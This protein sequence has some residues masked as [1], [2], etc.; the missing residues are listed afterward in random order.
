M[1]AMPDGP[2]IEDKIVGANLRRIR[3]QAGE[4][5]TELGNALGITFQ[6]IQKYEKGTNRISASR[7]VQVCRHYKCPISDLFTGIETVREQKKTTTSELSLFRKSKQ[8]NKLI[9]ALVE[10][11]ERSRTIVL[12]MALKLARSHKAS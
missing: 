10:L 6:Q 1:K 8:L 9:E 3:T 4:S 7:V 5:Q 11:D 12:D 2:R